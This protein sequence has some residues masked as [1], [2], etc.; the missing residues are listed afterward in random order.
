[1]TPPSGRRG[2]AR[3]ALAPRRRRLV[4]TV[5]L[6]A[7][8]LSLAFAWTWMDTGRGGSRAGGPA[9]PLSVEHEGRV[10]A[11]LEEGTRAAPVEGAVERYQVLTVEVTTGDRRGQVVTAVATQLRS[12]DAPRFRGGDGV[13]VQRGAGLDGEEWVVVDA[14]RRPALYGLAAVFVAAVVAAGGERRPWRA[15]PRAWPCSAA[16]CSRGSSRATARSSLA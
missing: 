8:G 14:V 3:A 1:M 4:W 12:V 16:T 11:V 10:R 13:V 6:A 7:L 9:A 15:S 5:A 2:P